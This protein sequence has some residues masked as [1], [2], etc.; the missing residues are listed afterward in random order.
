MSPVL[1]AEYRRLLVPE[2][3]MKKSL[4]EYCAFMKQEELTRK[5]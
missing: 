3:V 4:E 2:N 1:V 5:G